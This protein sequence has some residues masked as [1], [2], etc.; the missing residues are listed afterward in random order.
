MPEIPTRRP[1]FLA[2]IPDTRKVQPVAFGRS[3]SARNGPLRLPNRCPA[4]ADPLPDEIAA[5]RREAMERVSEA[6]S[7]LRLQAQNVADQARAD[8]LE[9]AFQVA[10]RILEAEIHG[11]PEA[12]FGLVR[13]ALKR[14][15]ESRRI[16]VRLSPE[17]AALVDADRQRVA[18]DALTATRI[19][20]L[21][22]PALARGDV[23]VETDFGKV[24]GRL[25]TRLGEA[26]RAVQS[27]IDG[28][29]A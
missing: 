26:R 7:V 20:V 15:G 2:A 25:Q 3:G 14:A 18:P 28:D 21:A 29:A 12:L 1:Q 13:S 16:T 19:E 4:A 5:V 11:S 8:A 24:D 22:D 10:R 17:D 9:I 23:V 6:V 27:A